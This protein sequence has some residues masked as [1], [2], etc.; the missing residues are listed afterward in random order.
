MNDLQIFFPILHYIT[1]TLNIQYNIINTEYC[2]QRRQKAVEN[3]SRHGVR[4]FAADGKSPVPTAWRAQ[5]QISRRA[6]ISGTSV[7][8]YAPTVGTRAVQRTC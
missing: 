6:G 7:R 3:T 8:R 1:N 5:V 2:V 4:W